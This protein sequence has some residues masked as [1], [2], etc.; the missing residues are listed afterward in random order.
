MFAPPCLVSSVNFQFSFLNYWIWL[1][2]WIF[3]KGCEPTAAYYAKG[4]LQTI[5]LEKLGTLYQLG[6]SPLPPQRLGH[7]SKKN[8]VYFALE[9]IVGIL[10]FLKNIFMDIFIFWL[11][12][13]YL[14]V[15]PTINWWD[16]TLPPFMYCVFHHIYGHFPCKFNFGK[17]YVKAPLT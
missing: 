11:G 2:L 4:S 17:F 8:D 15:Q 16:I 6:W 7:Q 12:L 3:V 5:F 14:G 9:A 1:H 10:V 13:R